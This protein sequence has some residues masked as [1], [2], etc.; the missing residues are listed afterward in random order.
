ME[1]LIVIFA[2]MVIFLL[3]ALWGWNTRER[4]A[5]RQMNKFI[6]KFEEKVDETVIKVKMEKHHDMI[7]MY[8]LSDN[9][10]MAQGRNEEEI[11]QVLKK[12]FPEK[13]FAASTVDLKECGF[14]DESI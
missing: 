7:Y 4:F 6:E 11:T 8:R 13:V 12:K 14:K 2:M 3:G 10:F 1:F 5:E 9:L